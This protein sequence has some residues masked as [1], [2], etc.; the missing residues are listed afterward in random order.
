MFP[1][2]VESNTPCPSC[3]VHH[4]CDR[5][6]L[7]PPHAANQLRCHRQGAHS[8]VSAARPQSWLAAFTAS[9]VGEKYVQRRLPRGGRQRPA[10]P[11]GA[12]LRPLAERRS[13]TSG[14]ASCGS[15]RPSRAGTC[16]TLIHV[17]DVEHLRPDPGRQRQSLASAP[18]VLATH[19]LIRGRAR[20]LIRALSQEPTAEERCRREHGQGACHGVTN[21]VS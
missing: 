14:A 8:E 2:S 18:G 15:Y 13:T 19:A 20:A 9:V 16:A 5:R 10:V 6:Q 4:R 12:C 3:N 17:A 7:A 11:S 1:E 21:S